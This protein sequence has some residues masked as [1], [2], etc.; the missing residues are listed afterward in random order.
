MNLFWQIRKLAFNCLMMQLV[1]RRAGLETWVW[2]IC[3]WDWCTMLGFRWFPLLFKIFYVLHNLQ[4]CSLAPLMRKTSL[5]NPKLKFCCCN[6]TPHVMPALWIEQK[7]SNS[8]LRERERKITSTMWTE[9]NKWHF[10]KLA[11]CQY[12]CGKALKCPYLSVKQRDCFS[13]SRSQG[14]DSNT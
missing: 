12:L 11:V 3:K 2:F 13:F 4:K 7:G 14:T 9:H 6:G 1:S 8:C 10:C 5:Y